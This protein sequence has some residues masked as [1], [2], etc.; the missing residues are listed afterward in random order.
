LRCKRFHW[1][2]KQQKFTVKKTL[3]IWANS[4]FKKMWDDEITGQH[5]NINISNK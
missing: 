4:N 5:H 1:T 2:E 3:N